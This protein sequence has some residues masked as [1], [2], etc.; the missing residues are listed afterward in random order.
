MLIKADDLKEIYP[1]FKDIPND[2]LTRKLSVIE[3]AIRQHTNNNFQNRMFRLETNVVGG[4]INWKNDYLKVGDTIQISDGINKG[5]YTIKSVSDTIETN[6]PLYDYPKQLITK[7]E[8]PIE[9][10]DG[11]IDLLD[12]ELIQKGKENTGVASETISR[13]SVNY[14]QRTNDNT[15]KGFPIELF[16]FCDDYMKARF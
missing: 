8:Y 4:K 15:I 2:L 10:I 14:V 1:K 16:N 9:V 6:E 12:W 3:S 7:I 5:L 13:H 11:A